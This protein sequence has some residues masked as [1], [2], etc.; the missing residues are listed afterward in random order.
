MARSKLYFYLSSLLIIISFY[1][2]TRNP[3]LN[4]HFNSIIKLIFVCSI[5]NAVILIISIIFADKS[6][7]HSQDKSDWIRKASKILPFVLLIVII[8]HIL[9]SLST[10][11]IIF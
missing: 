9:S 5:I 8:I 10:F 2:N 7:K 4:M 6:I 3:L 1:F 11:G